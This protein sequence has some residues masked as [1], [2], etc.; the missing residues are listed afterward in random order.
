MLKNISFITLAGTLTLALSAPGCIIDL[1]DGGGDS[2]GSAGDGDGDT[3]G[4]GD[5]EAEAGDGDGD[6]TTGDG[7]ETTGDGDE[8]GDGDGDGPAGAC[9]WAESDD[10]DF[11][12]G[13][14]CGGVGEDPSG[15]FAIGCP[16]DLVAGEDCG[17]VTGAG[18]CD[19]DGN[20]WFCT[21]DTNLLFMDDCSA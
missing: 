16:A 3:T 11:I 7:D 18:C 20:N 13:Y 8:A 2:N 19:A 10:P 21:E 1:G 17:T 14:Y 12:N 5:G 6:E 4:D 15:T 9:G